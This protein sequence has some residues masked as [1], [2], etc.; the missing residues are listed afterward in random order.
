[1]IQNPRFP[2]SHETLGRVQ[3]ELGDPL[4]M[5]A[6]LGDL[7]RALVPIAARTGVPLPRLTDGPEAYG[8]FIDRLPENHRRAALAAFTRAEE[9]LHPHYAALRRRHGGGGR[10]DGHGAP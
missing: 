3:A 7:H 6:L 4:V 1:M 8:R 2:S 5:V 10:R 9:R